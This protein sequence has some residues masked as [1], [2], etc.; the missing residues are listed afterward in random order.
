MYMCGTTLVYI[1]IYMCIHVCMYIL[2]VCN[3]KNT[4]QHILGGKV[5]QTSGAGTICLELGTFPNLVFLGGEATCLTFLSH[6]KNSKVYM[7]SYENNILGPHGPPDARG[8][9]LT[10][11]WGPWGIVDLIG[12]RAARAIFKN[13]QKFINIGFKNKEIFIQKRF[14]IIFRFFCSIV[15][16][17]FLGD[18]MDPWGSLE[19]LGDRLQ[20]SKLV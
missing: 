20:I 15:F 18:R 13:F 8:P 2:Y 11:A 4:R 1:Y 19:N 17:G 3:P 14:F 16:L 12:M 9:S 6:H 7:N 5:K 10:I